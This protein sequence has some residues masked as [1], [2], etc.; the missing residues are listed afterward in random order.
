MHSSTSSGFPCQWLHPVYSKNRL[1]SHRNSTTA[2]RCN[3]HCL[4][5]IVGSET[6]LQ[7][8][9]S[10][11]HD[12]DLLKSFS[13]W[14]PTTCRPRCWEQKK[15]ISTPRF[16]MGKLQIMYASPDIRRKS[17]TGNDC[18]IRFIETG[19]TNLGCF[20]TLVLQVR[21]GNS[22]SKKLHIPP[23]QACSPKGCSV[24]GHGKTTFRCYKATLAMVGFHEATAIDYPGS[25]P[26]GL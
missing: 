25:K 4:A 23:F 12:P 14:S 15:R 20:P 26:A 11:A 7:S 22:C 18:C 19:L 21:K 2:S 8:P 13:R 17:C 1:R 3:A 16:T 5:S 6:H 9:R 24:Q 10:L